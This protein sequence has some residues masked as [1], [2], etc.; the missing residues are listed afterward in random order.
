MYI[1]TLAKKLI[2]LYSVGRSTII[3]ESVTKKLKETFTLNYSKD[4]KKKNQSI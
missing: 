2:E 3:L 1:I 4:L